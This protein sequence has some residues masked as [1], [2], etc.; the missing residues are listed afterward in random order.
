M[1]ITEQAAPT[2][3]G[4]V[5]VLLQEA[6]RR[7]RRRRAARSAFVVVA[8]A[9]VASLVFLGLPDAL[10]G[11]SGAAP[12]PNEVLPTDA[13]AHWGSGAGFPTLEASPSDVACSRRVCAAVGSVDYQRPL[14]EYSDDAGRHWANATASFDATT[15]DAVSCPSPTACIAVGALFAP[16]RG[17]LR[18]G[19]AMWSH[20][21]G[22]TW[23][24]AFVRGTGELDAVACPT[25]RHCIAAGYLGAAESSFD[26]AAAVSDDGGATWRLVHLPNAVIDNGLACSSRWSCTLVGGTNGGRG[27]AV[28]DVSRNGGVT[29]HAVPLGAIARPG[30]VLN[31]VTCTSAAC[32]ALGTGS[33][34]A[35][36]PGDLGP[37]IGLRT[38]DAGRTWRPVHGLDVSANAVA[39][40]TPAVCVV[41]GGGPPEVSTDGGATWHAVSGSRGF[42]ISVAGLSCVSASSCVA[43][44]TALGSFDG[45]ILPVDYGY[46]RFATSSDAG[47]RWTPRPAAA[48]W[49]IRAI[50][51]PTDAACLGVG[52]TSG[53]RASAFELTSTGGIE[54]VS[55]LPRALQALVDVS[56]TGRD[57]CVAVGDGA[58][59]RAVAVWST[60]RGHRWH[61]ARLPS[62]IESLAAVSC[63]SSGLCLAGGAE[64][65]QPL[66]PGGNPGVA[67]IDCCDG[68]LLRSSDSGRTWRVLEVGIGDV[69]SIS[70]RAPMGPCLAA[71]YGQLQVVTDDG[72]RLASVGGESPPAGSGTLECLASGTCVAVGTGPGNQGTG[73][74]DGV[75]RSTDLGR[76]WRAAMVRLSSATYPSS[77]WSLG[78]VQCIGDG[79]CVTAGGDQWYGYRALAVVSSPDDQTWVQ[80]RLPT[81]VGSITALGCTSEGAC[82]A[83]APE[84]DGTSAVFTVHL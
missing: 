58:S 32:V 36:S 33:V 73:N 14:I 43:A 67:E 61:G 8:L 6:K 63:S 52:T 44:G 46:T 16:A 17:D 56:C 7:A 81:G 27:R 50:T 23:S 9:G 82:V 64:V 1:T 19:V 22:R 54:P 28:I 24:G 69:S 70:C 39:C 72:R 59:S 71:E 47:R 66:P 74:A 4:A 20:D 83:T 25:T 49:L 57:R 80:M 68:V 65:T 41:A 75:E 37:P 53:G 5:E 35:S 62:G 10:G 21:G 48:G 34:P 77:M 51:C 45:S 42:G 11:P 78:A 3:P 31:I 12:R 29:W 13:T 30:S 15:L 79:V 38:D 40:A 2:A 60:D 55:T 84:P 18:P 26:S 76:R